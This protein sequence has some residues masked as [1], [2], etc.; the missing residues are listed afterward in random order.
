MEGMRLTFKD[1][2]TIENGTAGLAEGCLWLKLPGYSMQQA[3]ALA[4]DEAKTEEIT[5]EYG[6]M[7]DVYD[8][9]TNCVNIHSDY[10]GLVSVCMKKGV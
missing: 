2:T 4:F 9:Y 6:E 10:D 1:G 3:A 5:F 7:Q 8:G